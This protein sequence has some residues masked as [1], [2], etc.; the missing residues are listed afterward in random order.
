MRAKN[1][2]LAQVAIEEMAEGRWAPD[3]DVPWIVSRHPMCE[4]M[5]AFGS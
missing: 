2:I 5:P 4:E 1:H 3:P